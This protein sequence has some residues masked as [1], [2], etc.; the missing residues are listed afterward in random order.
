[1]S[2]TDRGWPGTTKIDGRRMTPQAWTPP[3]AASP[4]RSHA[5]TK[6]SEPRPESPVDPPDVPARDWKR[7]TPS[8]FAPGAPAAPRG[9][10]GNSPSWDEDDFEDTAER[11]RVD[12]PPPVP[13]PEVWPVES[14]FSTLSPEERAL[15]EKVL[16][17]PASAVLDPEPVAVVA[18]RRPPPVAPAASTPTPQES[19]GSRSS[20]RVLVGLVVLFGALYVGLHA[21]A[22]DKLPRGTSVAGVDIGGRTA[23]DAEQLL[24]ADLAD[25]AA[26]PLEVTINGEARP[27]APDAA[28]LGVDYD[29]SIAGVEPTTW[30]LA[31]LWDYYF[32]G[33]DRD[34]ISTVDEEL[35][36]AVL[37]E[38]AAQVASPAVEG[39]VSFRG[40]QV[41]IVEAKSG[42]ALDTAEAA[43]AVQDDYLDPNAEIALT[44]RD[45]PPDIDQEDV[46]VAVQSFANP[47]VSGPVTLQFAKKS[48][49]L[50]P[51]DF[52]P[53]LSMR[54]EGGVLVPQVKAKKL[55]ALAIE[56]IGEAGAPLDATVRLIDG[57]PEVV[58]AEPGVSYLPPDV[59]SAFLSAAASA[60]EGREQPV[61]PT[62]TK[63]DFST[64]DAKALKIRRQVSTFTTYYPFAAYRNVNIPRAA[65]LIDGTVLKPGEIF[66]LNDTVGE[67]TRENGFTEGFVISDGLF[68]EDLGGGVSQIATTTYNAAF[69]AGLKDV[70]H[71]P[72]SVYIDR[73]PAGREATVA[74]GSVD[75]RF[76][77]D[78]PY[79]VLIQASV[80]RATPATPGV[81]T[82]S[83]WSAKYWDV[84]ASASARYNFT[85]AKTQTL[86]TEDCVPN[87]GYG[88]FEMDVTRYWRKPGES[89][90]AKQ[91]T[92]HT[93]YIPSDTVICEPP[94]KK[95]D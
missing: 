33:E 8:A 91:E 5:T 62:K 3:Q 44:L 92:K 78:T 1:M 49:R 27:I 16:Y 50:Q 77:N 54:P 35:L 88:G 75:L 55:T 64:K 82:V 85:P 21:L 71:K 52:T 17:E 61:N 72:H 73:Y 83:V 89:E 63:P 90:V 23:T 79:G 32:G 74:W 76:E 29:A 47:A 19:S 68:K 39:E 70:E 13:G 42:L 94:E 37:D 65:S 30:G 10:A 38:V 66:S 2:S 25:R 93:T 60:N 4:R 9:P 53:L 67:R 51:A 18:P 22:A 45:A 87:E 34:A 26:Q 14:G 28:G 48:F 81:V 15:Y 6:L 86:K 58:K 12:L 11:P 7:M 40:T 57:K 80:Q 56:S 24:R 46:K 95:N 43:A 31:S 20:L 84:T 36:S 59:G 69:F 41:V